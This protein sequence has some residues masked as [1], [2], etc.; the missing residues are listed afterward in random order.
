MKKKTDVGIGYG[1]DLVGDVMLVMSFSV[2]QWS[3]WGRVRPGVWVV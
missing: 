1:R 3:D 2:F